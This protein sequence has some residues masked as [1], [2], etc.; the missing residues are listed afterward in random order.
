[1]PRP[2]T[3][4]AHRRIQTE[5]LPATGVVSGGST[6]RAA[7]VFAVSCPRFTVHG[8]HL[9]ARLVPTET[10]AV[11]VSCPRGGLIR[12]GRVVARGDGLD[13]NA[14][15]TRQLPPLGSLVV[16]EDDSAGG[17]GHEVVVADI[18]YRILTLDDVSLAFIPVQR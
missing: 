8:I 7:D 12:Y 1:M 2:A 3:G 16:F 11:R 17:P 10:V 4:A 9:V 13:P 5:T 18:S 14:E 6:R 15:T